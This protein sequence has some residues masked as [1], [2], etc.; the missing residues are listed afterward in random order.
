MLFL[1]E[2]LP[3]QLESIS[4]ATEAVSTDAVSSAE[5]EEILFGAMGTISRPCEFEDDFPFGCG[6]GETKNSEL[7]VSG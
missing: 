4:L 1:L 7:T 6:K 3:S 5:S 2:M